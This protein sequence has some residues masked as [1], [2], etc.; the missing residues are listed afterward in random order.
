MKYLL[1]LLVLPATLV[2]LGCDDEDE[3]ETTPAAS[4]LVVGDGIIGKG[5]DSSPLRADFAGSGSSSTVARSDHTHSWSSITDA[6]AEV[7]PTVNELGKATLAC[8]IGDVATYDGARWGCSR[9]YA[10]PAEVDAVRSEV[11]AARD[12]EATLLAKIAA[13]EARIAALEGAAGFQ[14]RVTGTCSP[15]RPVLGINADGSVV[16]DSAQP[17]VTEQLASAGGTPT[18][19]NTTNDVF[20]S[21]N[22]QAGPYPVTT[23]GRPVR[24]YLK[25]TFYLDPG[26]ADANMT[27]VTISPV[28]D[29]VRQAECE[30]FEQMGSL[31]GTQYRSMTCDTVISLPAGEHTIGFDVG[32]YSLSYL[33]LADGS[34]V[35][36][37]EVE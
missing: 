16:C 28:I 21:L 18:T 7:D 25:A 23:S 11:V 34:A 33:V 3:A 8:D 24:V 9:D 31:F 19:N 2:G 4:E 26:T 5:S 6:P 13:L 14:A 20:T 22:G 27:R 29:G 37:E 10:R 15:G 12:G 30:R 35:V 36:V 1:R 17:L 32:S